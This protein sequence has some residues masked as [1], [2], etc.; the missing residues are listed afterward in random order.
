MVKR[1]IGR[2]VELFLAYSLGWAAKHAEHMGSKAGEAA[3][4]IVSEM[5]A[6]N[7]A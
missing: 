7:A 1:S 6:S 5:K 2:S 3:S 4:L